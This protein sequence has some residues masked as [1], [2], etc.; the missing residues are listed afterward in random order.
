MQALRPLTEFAGAKREDIAEN[1]P[2][3]DLGVS[4][5]GSEIAFT[6]MRTTFPLGSPAYVSPPASVPGMLELFDVDLAQDTLTRVTHGY[7]GGPS[8]QPHREVGAGSD[9]YGTEVGALSPSFSEDGNTLAFS[10]TASNLVYPDGNTPP[11][12]HESIIFDGSDAF[13]VSRVVFP[14]TPTPQ[15][16]SGAPDPSL[17]PAWDIGVTA[18]SRSNGSVLL[19]VQT[20]GSGTLRANAQSAVRVSRSRAKRS[21]S[22]RGTASATVTERTVAKQLA[23]TSLGGLT[24]L[25]LK[26]AKPYSTLAGEHGGLF[27]TV[28]VSFSA[29]GHPTVRQSVSVTFLRGKAPSKHS[30]RP[31]TA[32]ARYRRSHKG[33]KR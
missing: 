12:G 26:L 27:A 2:I 15:Y 25:S 31:P 14:A 24:V 16:V 22:H 32:S 7:E 8:E 1:A 21:S 19:Y 33:G 29:A 30:G 20:P 28:E 4:P 6:T 3:V 17:T 5:D 11:L 9:P 13:A 10:S 23:Q 18:L